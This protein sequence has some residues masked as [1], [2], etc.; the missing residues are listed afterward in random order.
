MNM[1]LLNKVGGIVATEIHGISTWIGDTNVF[2]VKTDV[3]PKTLYFYNLKE[4]IVEIQEHRF[5]NS[6]RIVAFNAC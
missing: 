6:F 3:D 1:N 4:H 5:P 2:Y